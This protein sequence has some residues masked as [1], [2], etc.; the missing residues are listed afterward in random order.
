[1]RKMGIIT[2]NRVFAQSLRTVI[3]SDPDLCYEPSM[4][5][6]LKQA[7]LDA[8]VLNLDLAVI[9]AAAEFSNDP[10]AVLLLCE[11]LRHVLPEC[12]V[13]LL[14]PQSDKAL[15]DLAIE[16]RKRR[17]IDDFVFYDSSL[18]YLLV[19]L[20]AMSQSKAEGKTG[21]GS[22]CEKGL[23]V[24]PAKAGIRSV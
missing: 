21:D 17:L 11:E 20:R 23:P 14:T 3:C 6:N 10:A 2:S 13:F 4:L 7:A 24:I 8:E 9:D 15:C 12:L 19:K 22:L 18:D 16:G 5:L 1:M